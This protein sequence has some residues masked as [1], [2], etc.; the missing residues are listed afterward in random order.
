MFGVL[1]VN[2]LPLSLPQGSSAEDLQEA[3][4][5]E[6]GAL[7]QE[8]GKELRGDSDQCEEGHGGSRS[9]SVCPQESVGR[10]DC[11]STSTTAA[12]YS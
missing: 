9:L 8:E 5:V 11:P 4:D 2:K 1:N 6:T 12:A 10:R 3:C 7:T